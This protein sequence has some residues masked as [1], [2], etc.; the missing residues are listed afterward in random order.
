MKAY[1]SRKLFRFL[2]EEDGPTAVEYAIM[3][4]AIFLTCVGVVG[5][6]GGA[7]NAKFNDIESKMPQ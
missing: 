5:T 6:M 7:L 2:H 1:L 4:A 3:L